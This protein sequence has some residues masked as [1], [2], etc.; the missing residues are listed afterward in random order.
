MNSS[1]GAL[2]FWEWI[3]DCSLHKCENEETVES[4]Y[5]ELL[6][7]AGLVWVAQRH[8]AFLDHPVRGCYNP[9][10]RMEFV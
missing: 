4:P 5:N 2:P 8:A 9:E 1:N 6:T 7:K 3:N 10:N